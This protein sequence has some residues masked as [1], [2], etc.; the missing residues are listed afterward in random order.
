MKL[1]GLSLATFLWT[2]REGE[3]IRI[4]FRHDERGKASEVEVDGPFGKRRIDNANAEYKPCMTHCKEL[5]HAACGQ[6]QKTE[7]AKSRHKAAKPKL[8]VVK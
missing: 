6:E 8:D 5:I 7:F 4:D 2:T 1:R 3:T